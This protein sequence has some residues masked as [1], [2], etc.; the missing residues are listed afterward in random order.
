MIEAATKATHIV[1]V[2]DDPVVRN[3]L[4]AYF[5]AEGYRVSEA[6]SAEALRSLLARDEAD[7]L[8][9]DINLPGEDGLQITRE[10]RGKS[11]VGIILLTGRTDDIDRI[12]GLEMGA[13]DYV[14]KPFNQR[15][16]WARVKNV[17]RRT[18][19]QSVSLRDGISFAGWTYDTTRRQL[20]DPDSNP[21]ELT[22]AEHSLLALFLAS[23][24]RVLTRDEILRHVSQRDWASYDRTPDVL[25]QRLRR[26]LGDNA[27][28]ARFIKTAHG[29]GYI[30][31]GL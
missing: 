1:L 14:T 2:D 6:D 31:V 10:I 12:V 24:G 9:I 27:R 17:L 25:V 13:D 23:N 22:H 26:K 3:K 21:V 18:R 5:A 4:S 8:L 20:A 19:G 11:D 28:E 7:L 15:E 16:L 29:E 30:F